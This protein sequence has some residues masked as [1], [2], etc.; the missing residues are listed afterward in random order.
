M[1]VDPRHSLSVKLLR[2]V[3]LWA[4]LAGMLLSLAQILFDLRSVRD[5]ISHDAADILAMFHDPA[6]QA[7]FSLDREMAIQVIDGLFAN[8]AVQQASIGHP[9]EQPL[10]SRTRPPEATYYRYLTDP[11]FSPE[12]HFSIPLFGKAPY[13]NH[14][15]DLRLSLDTAPYGGH[16]LRN[17]LIILMTGIL[18]ALF[19]ACAV[20]LLYHILLTRPLRRIIEHI[21]SVNPDHSGKMMVPMLPGQEKNELGLLI[22]KINQLLDVIERNRSGRRQAEASLLHL[23]RHDHLTGLP[24]RGLLLDQLSRVLDDAQRRQRNVA[25]LCCGLDDFKEINEKF[26]YQS[27]DQLLVTVAERLQSHSGRLTSVA[28]LGGDQFALI[29]ADVEETYEVAELAQQVL[30]DLN[31]PLPLDDETVALRATIGITLFPD[32]GMDPAKLLQKAEQT[33]ML[34]KTRSRN[35]FQ[36]YIASVDSEMRMRRELDSSL[37]DALLHNEFH[38]VY[39][40]LIDLNDQRLIGVEAL[41]RWHHPQRGM[42]P[43]DLFIPL[44]EQSGAIIAIGEWVMDQACQQLRK[45]QLAGMPELRMSVN[46]STVQLHHPDLCDMVTRTLERYGVPRHMLDLEVTETGLMEDIEAAARHL[47][48]LKATGVR[49][50]L[51]DFG[52]GYSSLSYLR[53]LPLDKIKIDK[54]FTGDLLEDEDDRNIVR[55][56]IQLGHNLN[57]QVI[58]EGVE[59]AEQESYLRDEGCDIGQGYFYSRPLTAS[60]LWVWMQN[61][62]KGLG[63]EPPQG[64]P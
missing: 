6:S 61:Y 58:A 49:I 59:C 60:A 11:L 15:G 63:S 7:M 42:V 45:W 43:P 21:G 16:F 12:R 51:D 36:F 19:M 57:M 18:R 14:Y 4:L 23:S 40:P 37:R 13:D 28:R 33:M 47:K 20:Y 32:D 34:A 17:S 26:S 24:N 44:A 48:Q 31:Q 8:A 54:S 53:G 29:V 52:T 38:L 62:Q 50:A 5:S 30:N 64:Q 39:Q 41:L 55:V 2:L 22:N 35:R 10:A 25:V 9:A 3:L 1:K 27:G 46:L 56:I